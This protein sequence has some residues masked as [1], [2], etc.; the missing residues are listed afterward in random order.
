MI[1]NNLSNSFNPVP[2]NKVEKKKEVTAIKKKSN[3]LAKLERQ[4]DKDI[5]KEGICE[6]CGKYS[7]RLDPHEIFGGSNRKR[8]IQH[9]FVKLICPK[10]HSN[11]AIINQLRIDTQK[12]YEKTHTRQEFINLIGKSYLRRNENE[13]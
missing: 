4:R 3:K 12:E 2:K 13:F 9:K 11:E 1:V 7:K 10:C 8:S 6:I 5:V